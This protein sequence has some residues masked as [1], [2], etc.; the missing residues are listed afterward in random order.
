ME[1]CDNQPEIP[2]V[3]TTDH[4][5]KIPVVTTPEEEGDITKMYIPEE[6]DENTEIA[7]V[8]QNTEDPEVNA[9]NAMHG[10]PPES[11]PT[12]DNNT[13]KFYTVKTIQYKEGF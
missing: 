6:E 9:N 5:E 7:G 12:S 2:G 4:Q 11:T 13:P 10:N 8:D 1:E 3:T